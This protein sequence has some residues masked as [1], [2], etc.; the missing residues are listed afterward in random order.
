MSSNEDSGWG[1]SYLELIINGEDSYILTSF[2]AFEQFDFDIVA[3]DEIE[4]IFYE[5]AS[6]DSD[7]LSVS[8]YNCGFLNATTISDL[9]VGTIFSSASECEASPATGMWLSLIHI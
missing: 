4:I 1:G 3:G 2:D 6:I 7:V 5:D 8:V 9:S